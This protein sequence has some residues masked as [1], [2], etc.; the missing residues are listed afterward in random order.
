MFEEHTHV[1]STCDVEWVEEQTC[2]HIV[3]NSTVLTTATTSE[4][5]SNK[6]PVD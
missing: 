1:N 2:V 4:H 6:D 3:I 5:E